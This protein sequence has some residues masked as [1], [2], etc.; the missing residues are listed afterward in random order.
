MNYIKIFICLDTKNVILRIQLNEKN[1]LN[2]QDGKIE[3]NLL[4]SIVIYFHNKY[5]TKIIKKL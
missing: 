4:F 5:L 2:T 3:N 1:E